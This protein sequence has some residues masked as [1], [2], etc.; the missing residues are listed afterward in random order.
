MTMLWIPSGCSQRPRTRSRQAWRFPGS[1]ALLPHDVPGAGG[2]NDGGT[3]P[4]RVAVGAKRGADLLRPVELPPTGT[5]KPRTA[6]RGFSRL[7]SVDSDAE[8]QM[9]IGRR[10]TV[11]QEPGEVRIGR[12]VRALW[13]GA[14]EHGLRT[15]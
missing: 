8:I 7:L 1:G 10:E 2:G 15:G 14:A 11:L 13:D 5:E 12:R 4:S 6:F 9:D 3:N